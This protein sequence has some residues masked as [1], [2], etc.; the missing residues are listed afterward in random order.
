MLLPQLI[1]SLAN[2]VILGTA[3]YAIS[4]QPSIATGLMVFGGFARLVCGLFF[5]VGVFFFDNDYER[6]AM[7]GVPFQILAYLGAV[8]FMVGFFMFAYRLF[9]VRA[10]A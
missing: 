1:G 4:R 8:A 5:A 6:Y 7:V 3:V 9:S 2:V 10:A